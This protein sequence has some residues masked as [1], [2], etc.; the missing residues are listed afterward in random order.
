MLKKFVRDEEG[1]DF[2]EYA[3]LL[4]GIVVA[5]MAAIPPVGAAITTIM[6]SVSTQLTA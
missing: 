4:S 6:E 5:A 2:I 3:L 1:Q